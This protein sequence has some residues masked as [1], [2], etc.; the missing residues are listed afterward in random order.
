M[1]FKVTSGYGIKRTYSVN[2]KKY[3]DVHKGIDLVP[4]PRNNNAEILAFD[5]GVV[6]SVCNKGKK[7]GQGCYVRINHENGYYSL[8]YHM[9]SGSI[10]VKKGKRVN[11]GDVLGIIGETGQ[12]TGVHLH[13]QIDKGSSSS[14][15]DPTNYVF[16]K[17]EFSENKKQILYLP[18]TAN[19]WRVYKLGIPPVKGNE[20]GFLRPLKFGGLEYEIIKRVSK[21]VVI[22][23]TRDFGRV[24]IYVAPDTGAV[25]K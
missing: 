8:Y 14:A 24:Q 11:K 25:I 19:S 20:C 21:N 9:K 22:I 3:T 5:S 16:G 17:K 2:G 18:K 12:A 6:T 7:G 10:K 23:D 15:I 4:N 13:F 1:N